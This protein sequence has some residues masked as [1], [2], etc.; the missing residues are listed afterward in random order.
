MQHIHT[1]EGAATAT[2]A[3]AASVKQVA[4]ATAVPVV[5]IAAR[6]P[7]KK[8]KAIEV[9]T[10]CSSRAAAMRKAAASPE[11]QRDAPDPECDL[12]L[13]YDLDR[14]LSDLRAPFIPPISTATT[15][16][17]QPPQ[18]RDHFPIRVLNKH[19]DW[20]LCSTCL[21]GQHRINALQCVRCDEKHGKLSKRSSAGAIHFIRL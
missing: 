14:D 16:I 6:L 21:C 11:I 15:W 4:G 18:P 13:S 7:R 17:P 12:D 2:T 10:R 5:A 20:F 19:P 1:N 8:A 3:P 9:P